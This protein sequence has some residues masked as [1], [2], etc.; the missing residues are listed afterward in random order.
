CTGIYLGIFIAFSFYF[1]T[2]II[3]NKKPIKPPAL[4]INILSLFFIFLMA[5]QA[6]SMLF[7]TIP[8]ENEVRFITGILFGF[9]LPW[10]LLI[11]LNYSKRFNYQNKEILNYKEYL[12]L[13]SIVLITTIIFLF[14]IDFQGALV[15]ESA[16]K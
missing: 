11:T 13:F 9:S 6:I 2:K 12:I 3:K 14:K 8:F 10:Y 5:V 4:W 15:L 16:A 7:I 1:L